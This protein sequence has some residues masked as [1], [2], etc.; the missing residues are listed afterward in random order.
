MGLCISKHSG[1]SYSY[2]DRDRWEEPVTLQTSEPYPVIKRHLR[3]IEP[4]TRWTNVLQH[5][6]I[7]NSRGAAKI[8]LLV[9][10]L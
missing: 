9:W 8:I 6:L 2:S 1:S 3:A 10:F 5:F 7:F 4:Q